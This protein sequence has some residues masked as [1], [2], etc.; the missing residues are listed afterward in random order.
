VAK[1][2]PLVCVKG[3][4]NE[5]EAI[6]RYAISLLALAGALGAV[7]ASQEKPAPSGSAGV[8]TAVHITRSV[9][10]NGKPLPAG[11]YELRL[12]NERPTPL[13]G[14]SPDAERWVEFVANGS[15][16]A[17]E[18]AEVLRDDDLPA[19]GA[20]SVPTREGTR[21]DLLRG[22]EFLRISVKRGAERYLVYLP[23]AP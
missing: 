17:R 21:I 23:V 13:P 10:V 1:L 9:V 12:T 5:K 4:A 2:V 8:L 22:G 19:E 15:V 11:M 14:Q 6:M 20:S 7:S 3:S 16:V 18:T